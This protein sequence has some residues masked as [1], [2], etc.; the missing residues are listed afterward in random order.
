MTAALKAE[1]KTEP[2]DDGD[3]EVLRFRKVPD[4]TK[5]TEKEAC[6][7]SQSVEVPAWLD[8]PV[9]ATPKAASIAPSG[10]SAQNE[11]QPANL[12]QARQRA[13]IRGGLMHRLLQSLPDIPA[14]RRETAAAEF[15]RRAGADMSAEQREA[16]ADIAGQALKLL[17]DARCSELFGPGS[18][19]EVPIVGTVAGRPVNGGL[20]RI[21]IMPAAVLIGDFKTGQRIDPPPS[22]YVTQ[23]ALYR[24]VLAKLYRDRP[25]RAAL[26]WTEVP[27]FVELSAEALDEALAAVTSA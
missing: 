20:D 21:A 3:G 17:A 1:C 25:I 2:A 13:M 22:S 19:A 8:R 7:P 24:A 4:E 18:R 12:A 14:D 27:E 11:A 15:L 23:L 16:V 6:A 5:K 9:A 10:F 26:I